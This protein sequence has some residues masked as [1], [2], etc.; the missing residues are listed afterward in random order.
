Q[1]LHSFPTRRSSDLSLWRRKSNETQDIRGEKTSK[2]QFGK[3]IY[4]RV[5][6]LFMS[7]GRLGQLMFTNFHRRYTPGNC[8]RGLGTLAKPPRSEEHTSEL[9]SRSD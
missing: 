1:D 5:D 8:L 2:H 9:Q 4:D 3:P 7:L 6:R